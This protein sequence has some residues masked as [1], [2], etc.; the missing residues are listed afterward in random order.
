MAFLDQFQVDNIKGKIIDDL[1]QL[2]KVY[3]A[4]KSN[5]QEISVDHSLVE[6]Y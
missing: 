6:G 5:Y 1:S 4:K 2:G 3:R